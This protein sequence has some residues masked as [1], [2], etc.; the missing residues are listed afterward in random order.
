MAGFFIL[1]GFVRYIQYTLR[2][3]LGWMR[4]GKNPASRS[5]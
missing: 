2:S 5:K 3:G 4:A 1:I